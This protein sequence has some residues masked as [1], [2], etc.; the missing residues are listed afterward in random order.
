MAD[1]QRLARVLV[2]L[3]DTLV[4]NFDVVEFLQM[5]GERSVELL[6]A[7]AAGLMLADQ[8]GE[9]QLMSATVER[10]RL[11]EVFALKIDEGPCRD[12][13]TSGQAIAN[14]E[15]GEAQERW[16][17]F[18]P[19]AVTAGFRSTHVL[20]L[21]L[22]GRVIGAL[23]LLCDR[24]V[25]L[26]SDDIA[27]GQA[28]A[29]VATIGL[30]RQQTSHEQVALTEQ[31]Q[32]ALKSRVLVEQAKGALAASA[33]ITVDEAFNRMRSHARR[34]GVTLQAVAVAVMDGSSDGRGIRTF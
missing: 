32:T 10:A 2:E 4:E 5:M 3:A 16:P 15:L 22:R 6:G 1:S 8:G 17:R 13:F 11:L 27:V 20:P 12:C 34:N 19:A 24:H 28:M 7:D 23:N 25:R 33:R 18:T 29:D 9:L 21:R 14:I 31:L 30:L 26:S